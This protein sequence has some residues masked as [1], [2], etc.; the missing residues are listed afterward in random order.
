MPFSKK[1]PKPLPKTPEQ[2]LKEAKEAGERRAR[3]VVQKS[4]SSNWEREILKLES[5]EAPVRLFFPPELKKEF[6]DGYR[7]QINI[8]LRNKNEFGLSDFQIREDM[9]ERY[10]ATPK[11][12]QLTPKQLALKEEQE[13]AMQGWKKK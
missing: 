10:R 2:F 9:L 13:K 12:N 5:G 6:L 1:S 8:A 11:G 4:K 7:T 3:S